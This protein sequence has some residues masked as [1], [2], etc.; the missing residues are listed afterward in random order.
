MSNSVAHYRWPVWWP[1]L[2]P[3]LLGAALFII[4][5]QQT[6]L[7]ADEGWTIAA[8]AESSPIRVVSEWVAVDVHPPLFFVNL[9]LWRLFTGDTI[10]EL[11]F[12]SV[13]WSLIGVALAYRIGSEMFGRRAGLLAALFYALHDLVAVLTQE[14]RHY[15]QQMALALLVPGLYWRFW[16]HPDRR[17]GIAFVL[18]GAALLYT[19]YW[20]GFVLLALALH[21]LMT[22]SRHLRP[23]L[24][25]FGGAG[26]MFAP[27]LPVLYHQMTLERP[28]GLPHAL[29]NSP[30]VYAVLVYQLVGIPEWLWL[31]LALVGA[32]GAYAAVPPRYRPSPASLIPLLVAVLPPVLSVLV[33]TVYPTLS[34]RS[35]AVIVPAVILLAAHG[36]AQF[37]A[38]ERRVVLAFIVTYS[39][40]SSSAQPIERHPWPEIATYMTQ[41]SSDG[42]VILLEND[43]DEFALVYYIEQTG[44]GIDV[45]HTEAERLLRTDTYLDYL[46]AALEG[47]NGLWVSRLGWPA[48]G[49][50]RLELETRG[51]VQSAPE[52][53]YGMYNDRPILVWRMDRAADGP[54][55]ATFDEVL[56]LLRA[57]AV[58]REDGVRVNLLWSPS[59]TP[60]QEYTV[61]AFVLGPAFANHDSRPLDGRSPTSGWEPD[62]LYFDSLHVSTAGLPLG[63]YV[64][65]VQVYSFADTDF[66]QIVNAP[67]D[68]CGADPDCRFIVID[69]LT[70]P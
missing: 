25:A 48:L 22:R 67:V 1:A 11:R 23:F 4:G 41:R 58:Q 6:S 14:V 8:S 60:A 42:D 24:L 70:L 28:G 7:W 43:T 20:G 33:N 37:R 54:P 47:K 34:F 31:I 38:R 65:G 62:G 32:F 9:N 29:E 51:W 63:E 16:Q 66:S 3:L 15:P 13:L 68:D 5:I 35:L 61:S 12:F 40:T 10:L 57:E 17:H 59:E 56:R 50:I 45:A 69:T 30:H 2:L 53:D 36:L 19:H 44:T 27:W 46:D 52:L 49:D 18:G 39:L 26:L 55:R 21:A 64:V